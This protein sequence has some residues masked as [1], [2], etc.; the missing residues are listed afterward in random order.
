[1]SIG[2]EGEEKEEEEYIITLRMFVT[3]D[4]VFRYVLQVESIV[5]LFF[6][7]KN[8]SVKQHSFFISERP[9][10]FEF[11]VKERQAKKNKQ[12]KD[13]FVDQRLE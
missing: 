10:Q 9:S 13:C 4:I 6:L 11:I 8:H 12:S 7:R 1:M 2:K 5:P 3:E